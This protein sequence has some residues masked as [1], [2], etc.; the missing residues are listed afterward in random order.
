MPIAP[1]DKMGWLPGQDA[2]FRAWIAENGRWR[3]Y[4]A[5]EPVYDAGDVGDALY[6]LGAGSLDITFPLVGDEPVVLH[7]AEAGFWIGESAVLSGSARLLSLTAAREARL[8]RV[9]GARI[10][11]LVAER[12]AML[13]PFYTLSHANTLL[14]LTLLAEAL[15]LTPRARLARILLRLADAESRVTARQDEL[16]RLLGMTRSS[17]QRALGSLIEAGA[18]VPGYGS[19]EVRDRAWLAAIS[20]EA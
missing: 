15:A 11:A 19:L 10:R 16:A 9:P 5:G 2:E 20:T 13:R 14:A 6:G 12:P 1:L 7:R 17:L 18:V 4:A 3:S 8:F